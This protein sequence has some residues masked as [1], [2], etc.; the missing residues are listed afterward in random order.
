MDVEISAGAV[1]MAIAG[2]VI[3]KI[4]DTVLN[5]TFGCD[6][7]IANRDK[8]RKLK[9]HYNMSDKKIRKI[10]LDLTD[11]DFIKTEPSNHQEHLQDEVYVFKKTTLLMPRLQENAEYQNIT[12]YIKLTWPVGVA[13]KMFIISFHEDNI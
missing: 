13:S 6:Y 10:L 1:K 9:Q 7:T 8:Y 11:T 12:I 2:E 3:K 4:K 5:G